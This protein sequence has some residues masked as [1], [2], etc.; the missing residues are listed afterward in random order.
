[1]CAFEFHVR[2]THTCHQIKTGPQLS[3]A[4]MSELICISAIECVR[5]ILLYKNVLTK[6]FREVTTS[7]ELKVC[8]ED[9]EIHSAIFELKR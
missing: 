3:R 4:V 1:M 2:R 7:Y 8:R 9:S 6:V 5:T